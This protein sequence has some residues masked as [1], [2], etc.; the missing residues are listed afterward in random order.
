MTA[1]ALHLSPISETNPQSAPGGGLRVGFAKFFQIMSGAVPITVAFAG[2]GLF[3]LALSERSTAETW[4]AVW[5]LDKKRIEEKIVSNK[6]NPKLFAQYGAQLALVKKE[7]ER[8]MQWKQSPNP[9]YRWTT[10]SIQ[11][12]G[13][14][15]TKSHVVL[16]NFID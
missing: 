5:E 9:F 10:D 15:L 3:A 6:D 14:K 8:T 13:T 1:A 4:L 7:I 16:R 11:R 12:C 2:F